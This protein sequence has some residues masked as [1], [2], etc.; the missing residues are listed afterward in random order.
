MSGSILTSVAR[1][2]LSH[3]T[4][5][6]PAAAFSETLA[7]S[8]FLRT[9]RALFSELFDYA[10]AILVFIVELRLLCFVTGGAHR[11]IKRQC[12]IDAFYRSIQLRISNRVG[13]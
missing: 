10:F 4:Q 12:R 11:R 3:P 7:R 9:L 1:A 5:L 2:L 6:S 8:I 13:L